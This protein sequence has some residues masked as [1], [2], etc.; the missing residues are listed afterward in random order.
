MKKLATW[1][2]ILGLLVILLLVAVRVAVGFFVT[3]DG[4]RSL[5]NALLE[6]AAHSVMPTLMTEVK[7]L[8]LS[9][10][11]DLELR[12]VRILNSNKLDAALVLERT[13]I[14]PE[15]AT[16]LSGGTWQFSTST[17]IEGDGRLNIAAT[18]P[19]QF[20]FGSRD[21][22]LLDEGRILLNGTMSNVD[23]VKLAGLLFS[24]NAAPG[25]YLSQGLINATIELSQPLGS[26]HQN[27][28]RRGHVIGTIESPEWTIDADKQRKLPSAPIELNLE[29]DQGKV[30]LRR[31]VVMTGRG[32]QATITGALNLPRQ[33]LDEEGWNLEV[34][35]S[36]DRGLVNSLAELF[37]CKSAPTSPRFTIKGAVSATDCG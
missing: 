34:L 33:S 26:R 15:W 24:D 28:Q 18:V 7:S 13:R 22:S 6:R 10:I 5:V 3:T 27:H 20:F 29:L 37:K 16:I 14:S 19:R 31:P 1:L 32:G 35:V 12:Q 9:G 4:V 30:Y 21:P 8:E 36:D 23:A 25:F 2:G 11:A 17:L